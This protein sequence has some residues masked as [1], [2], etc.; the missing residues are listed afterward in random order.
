MFKLNQS[1]D[2]MTGSPGR[3]L[4]C[5]RGNTRTG[6]LVALVVIAGLAVGGLWY[7]RQ[8]PEMPPPATPIEA[9]A[10]Y[11]L[12]D[13]TMAVLR[14]LESPVE[15]TFHALL[16]PT[17]AP[18]SVKSLAGRAD[19]M[20]AA[21]EQA[22]GSRLTV[23]RSNTR[24]SESENAA[25]KD[26]LRDLN[27]DQG[28]PSFLG[29]AVMS[30]DKKEVLPLL[31][32]WE[33]AMES[34]LARAIARVS[35]VQTLARPVAEDPKVAERIAADVHRLIPDVKSTSVEEGTRLLRDSA[36]TEFKAAV[37]EMQQQLEV[38]R[39]GLS[40]TQNGQSETERA[41]ALKQLQQVQLEQGEKLKEI[42]ARLQ[43]EI[44]QFQQL[45]QAAGN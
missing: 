17:H 32:E 26:G 34:D 45:K 36:L 38:A 15:I 37:A 41:T 16:D 4:K 31:P 8:K 19:E 12:S 21:F 3:S 2:A 5:V 35:A 44:E 39:K 42:S 28:D 9:P 30:R 22:A 11:A 27:L 13:G 14:R 24:S 1:A 43:N 23:K 33:L 25:A 29:L 10:G 6:V 40:E 7:A 18:E 20:L